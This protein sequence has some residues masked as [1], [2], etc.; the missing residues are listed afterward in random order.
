MKTINV[1]NTIENFL[2]G[3][4][5]RAEAEWLNDEMKK[6]PALVR[7][8]NLR[9]KTDEILANREVIDLRAKL[10]V[11]E[12]K[13]RSS[14]AM[15]KTML[16][17]AKYAA[18]LALLAVVTSAL[19]LLL[20]PGESAEELFS[21]NYTRYES[22]GAARSAVSSGNTLMENAIASYAARDYEKAI[23]F[24]EQVIVSERDNIESVFMHGVANMEISNYPKA[25]GSFSEVIEHN[26][27]LFLE[28]ASWYLG[29]CYM[30]TENTDKAVKQFEAI[31]ASKSR[32]SRQAARLARKLR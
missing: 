15:R 14:A 13:K 1:N 7:E 12:I 5:G 6:N 22:P 31:A 11:I 24:L 21:A 20:R 26:D 17:T 25:S 9:R 19:Y 16:K 10:A 30:M 18:A 27:N 3:T 4:A 28:D 8:V 23:T 2:G 29:L 32:Y